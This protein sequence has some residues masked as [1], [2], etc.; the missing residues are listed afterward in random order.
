MFGHMQCIMC[1]RECKP[2]RFLRVSEEERA[3]NNWFKLS[4]NIQCTEV[5]V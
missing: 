1:N 5:D 3:G 2:H 4:V